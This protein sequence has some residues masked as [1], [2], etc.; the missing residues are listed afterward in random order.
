MCLVW[1]LHYI[2]P[3]L[4]IMSLCG[5]TPTLAFIDQLPKCVNMLYLSS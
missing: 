2:Y 5:Y 4:D 1:R 3:K